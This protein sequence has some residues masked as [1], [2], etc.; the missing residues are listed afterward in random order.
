MPVQIGAR[1]PHYDD[2]TR[3]LSDCHRRIEMF[4]GNL[5]QVAAVQGDSLSEKEKA[6]LEKALHYFREAAPK[7]TAD[8]EESLF[9]RLRSKSSAE[10]VQKLS[11]MD[12]LE[13]DHR[14]ADALHSTVDR[15]GRLWVKSGALSAPD[16]Q[17]FRNAVDEL[18]AIYGKHIE[19]ED[20]AIFPLADRVLTAE[21]K[22][23]ISKEMAD[24]RK[25]K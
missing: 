7:H 5:Q 2:T 8:E 10:V 22:T 21:E 1:L 19:F 24:R 11:E 25:G 12:R 13:A 9:P 14:R 23:H 18:S 17:V 15:L 16:M 3:L 4:L 6:G 20:T